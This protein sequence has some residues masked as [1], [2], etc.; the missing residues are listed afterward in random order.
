LETQKEKARGAEKKEE[1][2][3]WR[4]EEMRGEDI[5]G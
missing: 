4:D 1:S 2:L 5:A 3:M